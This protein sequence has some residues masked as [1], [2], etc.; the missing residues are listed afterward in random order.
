MSSWR[1]LEY[2]DEKGE[3]IKHLIT[4]RK[5]QILADKYIQPDDVVLELG[6]RYGTVSCVINKKLKNKH[7]QV[8][9][10]PDDRVWQALEDNMERN[11][12]DFHIIK[13]FISAKKMKLTDKEDWR[14]YGTKSEEN[15]SSKIPSFTLQE[16]Q[17]K[18]KLK[19]NVLVAD[20]E[21]FLCQFLDEN[22]GFLDQLRLIIFEKDNPKMCNYNEIK[23][24]LKEKGFK[25]L[26]PLFREAWRRPARAT[27]KQ[28]GGKK[29]GLRPRIL[30]RKRIQY[31]GELNC[32]AEG[33]DNTMRLASLG[34]DYNIGSIH[35]DGET[36]SIEK[37][38]KILFLGIIPWYD[39]R[40]KRPGNEKKAVEDRR[41]FN[42]S[43]D[44]LK[45]FD[46]PNEEEEIKNML[47]MR[48]FFPDLQDFDDKLYKKL[49]SKK[50]T[51]DQYDEL[52]NAKIK[53]YTELGKHILNTL[54]ILG[55]FFLRF[56]V[57]DERYAAA[58]KNYNAGIYGF[59]GSE[60][61]NGKYG[62]TPQNIHEYKGPESFAKFMDDEQSF[63]DKTMRGYIKR[64]A[65]FNAQA[66][67]EA[68]FNILSAVDKCQCL[69]FVIVKEVKI[70]NNFIMDPRIENL[71]KNILNFYGDYIQS[72][73]FDNKMKATINILDYVLQID[74][75]LKN[76]PLTFGIGIV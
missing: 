24:S 36:W 22:P 20:C 26:C 43:K 48:P 55:S 60:L 18:Y 21:G 35:S 9:V 45:S 71:A 65:S 54:L 63:P 62:A 11:N 37:M 33:F 56:K 29:G 72:G 14:G 30:T 28:K 17:K 70:R 39:K 75:N 13:G 69:M 58:E 1:D 41:R 76:P 47:Y 74:N 10:E 50:I 31:G 44:E 25:Q 64:L 52:R 42:Y 59:L 12:C 19:F 66:L 5:E 68:E 34:Q 27:R 16:I 7:N 15:A 73:G 61:E 4:E 3:K 49:K 53:E 46:D 40:V 32:L 23:R 6:A 57:V 38:R 51:N 2:Y 8:V 67:S